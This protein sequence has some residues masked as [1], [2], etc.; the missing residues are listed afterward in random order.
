[1]TQNQRVLEYLKKNG[2]ITAR[3]ASRELGVDRLSARV[4]DLRY[5]PDERK[6]GIKRRYEIFTE[7]IEVKTRYGKARVARYRLV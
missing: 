1:M 5:K 3:E 4:F 2:S 6:G 7:M